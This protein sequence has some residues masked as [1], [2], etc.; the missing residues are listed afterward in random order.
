[1]GMHEF[2]QRYGRGISASPIE[3]H[4]RIEGYIGNL[5]RKG[6]QRATRDIEL[7]R[8][9]QDYDRRGTPLDYIT[10]QAHLV[11]E[12]GTRDGD[13]LKPYANTFS[14]L[15]RKQDFFTG[16]EK[17]TPIVKGKAYIHFSGVCSRNLLKRI[18]DLL[19]KKKTPITIP[20][21]MES[22]SLENKSYDKSSLIT[23]L[24]VLDVLGV[25][26]KLPL[27][28]TAGKAKHFSYVH[29]D[30]AMPLPT[31]NCPFSIMQA[32]YD[33]P[34]G[35][36]DI[37]RHA[38]MQKFEF[39]QQYTP[40]TPY[41][42]ADTQVAEINHAISGLA[43]EGL[44]TFKKAPPSKKGIKFLY[45]LT[46]TGKRLMKK[47]LETEELSEEF[48][49]KL[50]GTKQY[51]KLTKMEKGRVAEITRWAN[52]M[53]TAEQI[54]E[55]SEGGTRRKRGTGALAVAKKLKM[56]RRYVQNV[57]EIGSRPATLTRSGPERLERILFHI[58]S[59]EIKLWLTD[60]LKKN[61]ML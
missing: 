54:A 29:A 40:T 47:A 61:K 52:I 38:S 33:G 58:P 4:S 8:D 6:T 27:H 25:V 1:M 36:T 2:R 49:Q 37:T 5:S 21:M 11:E 13:A 10:L 15:C 12:A 34:K 9:I 57:M 53:M 50:L 3:L 31:E 39:L 22:L 59:P 46:R 17:Q 23:A 28:S 48:R 55:P 18:P 7:I 26:N 19:K 42:G 20:E 43:D 56:S 30:Y 51:E 32:L 16:Q 35:K 24:N 14:S 44:I 41:K 45:T 60:Y